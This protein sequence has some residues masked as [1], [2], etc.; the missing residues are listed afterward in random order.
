MNIYDPLDI[1]SDFQFLVYT[2]STSLDMEFTNLSNYATKL[3]KA[4]NCP[5]SIV[6]FSKEENLLATTSSAGHTVKIWNI[7]K[8]DMVA[9]FKRAT[10]SAVIHS[11]DFSHDNDFVAV[12]SQN[13]KHPAVSHRQTLLLTLRENVTGPAWFPGS[14]ARKS[15]FWC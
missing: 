1:Y 9:K 2:G 12:S 15:P 10:F 3:I 5:L 8:G 4:T 11:V 13:G 14:P 7:F 6:K